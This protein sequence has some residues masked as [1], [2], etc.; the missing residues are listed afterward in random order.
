MTRTL[1]HSWYPLFPLL[2]H[3]AAK[4]PYGAYFTKNGTAVPGASNTR[5]WEFLLWQNATVPQRSDTDRSAGWESKN[6]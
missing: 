1:S 6:K 3:A 4:E 2:E 5:L